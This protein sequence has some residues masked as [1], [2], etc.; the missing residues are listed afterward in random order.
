MNHQRLRLKGMVFSTLMLS[1][2][3]LTSC[4]SESPTA[5][6]ETSTAPTVSL[7]ASPS[8][9][10]SSKMT[11]E[12]AMGMKPNAEGKCAADEPIKGKLSKRGNKIFYEPGSANYQQLKSIECFKT[13]ADAQKAGYHALKADSMTKGSETKTK[14]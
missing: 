1:A 9:M 13:A 14:N 5:K 7:S 10:S 2:L 4:G 12:N 3:V 11:P 6:T 8:A